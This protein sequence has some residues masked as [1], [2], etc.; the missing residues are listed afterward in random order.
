MSA[1][2]YFCV[3]SCTDSTVFI[4]HFPLYLLKFLPSTSAILHVYISVL[5]QLPIFK[6]RLSVMFLE[7]IV[8]PKPTG[9]NLDLNE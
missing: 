1:C 9:L 4:L 8:Q 6:S 3:L 2:T 5:E 7:G